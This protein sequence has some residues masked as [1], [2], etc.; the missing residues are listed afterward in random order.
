MPA[1]LAHAPRSDIRVR[2]ADRGDIDALLK[3]E[4]R[5]FATDRLSRRSL[6]RFLQS[7]GAEVLVAV[8]DGELAGTAIV[9][10]RARS[11]VARL[12]SIA[13]APHAGGRGVAPMLLDAAEAAAMARGCRLMR[14]EVHHTNHAAISRY[15][16]S[17][18][19]EFGRH[20]N[21]YEDGGDALR[22][23]KRLVP[24]AAALRNAPPYFHQSTDFTCGPACIM[25]A[26]GWADRNFRPAPAFEF[27]LWREA[28][29]MFSGTG[30]GGCE[31][32]GMAVT[33]RRHGVRSEIHVSRP[34]PYFL[35]NVRSA[36]KR[37][38]MALTQ[39]EFVREARERDIPTHL[40]PV[41]ESLLMRTFD[42]G[43]VA[44]VLVSGYHMIPRGV[45]HWIF[46]FGR[47][48]RHVLMHD[49]AAVRDDQGM[50]AAAETYAV[51]WTAFE[52]VIRVGRDRLSAAIVIRKGPS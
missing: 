42:A 16:K 27:A 1:N 47:N 36:D 45:P 13:V 6:R 2:K 41:N 35:D 12:Y 49:P 19:R 11:V 4:H 28:T 46:A 10:F 8:E 52:R 24:D 48:G 22:F 39:A 40:S 5:V 43:N 21:Y 31:P 3:L 17:G 7:P 25:M 51:P 44:I 23:E 30:P 9:L 29:T 18:Y 26:L 50:A 38:A 34:G 33:L 15:R 37:R 32:Y 20:R 14:L